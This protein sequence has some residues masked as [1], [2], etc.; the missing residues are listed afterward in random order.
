MVLKV[1]WM[2]TEACQYLDWLGL[3]WCEKY[4]LMWVDAG[5]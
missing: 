2:K 1:E 4:E 3:Y 5:L